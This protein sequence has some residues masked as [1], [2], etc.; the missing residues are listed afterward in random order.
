MARN[1]PDEVLQGSVFTLKRPLDGSI[2]CPCLSV[3][4][5]AYVGL[6]GILTSTFCNVTGIGV[7]KVTI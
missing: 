6:A 7:L 1:L 2:A 5:N 3:G 4:R